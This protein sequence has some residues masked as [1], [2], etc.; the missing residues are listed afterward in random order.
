MNDSEGQPPGMPA[1]RLAGESVRLEARASGEARINQAG[2]DQHFYYGDGV[3]GA[4]RAEPGTHVQECP[5][6]GLAAFGREQARWFFGRDQLT[7]GLIARLD[8]RLRAGG[9]QVVV[10]PS[11]AGKSSLLH[12]GL[13]PKLG[14]GAL[15]GS[16]RWPTLMF[17]PTAH[18]LA[19]LATQ[20][21][22]LTNTADPASLA[23]ELATDSQRCVE[24]L[25][26]HLSNEDSEAR[27]V[28][29]V[30]QFE[31]LFTLC[32]DDQQRRACI[33]VLSQLASPRS[34]SASD[35][36]PLGLVVVGVRADFYAACA[37]DA[38]L[39]TALEDNPLVIGPMSDTELREAILYPAQDVG[40]DVEPGL[41]E[42][43]LRD[44]GDTGSATGED[45]VTSYQAGRL[46]R[47]CHRRGRGDQL[48][49]RAA[50]VAGARIAGHLAA[51]PWSHPDRGG[52]S[53]HR[54]N[55]PCRGNHSRE[56]LHQFGS[57]QSARRPDPVP[58][59]GQIGD[60]TEDTRRRMARTDLLQ[61]LDPSSALPVLDTFTQGRLLTQDQG[62]IEITHEAL[63]RAWPRLRTWIDTDR[64]GLLI[65]QRLADDAR[66]WKKDQ[67]DPASLYRGGRLA[68]V[69]VWADDHHG[70]LAPL[71]RE[72]LDA[73]V[74][75]QES[76]VL[77]QQRNTRRLR[78]LVGGLAITLVLVLLA[79]GATVFE[80]HTVSDQRR[81]AVARELAANS[82]ALATKDP[83]ASM[84]LAVEA[85]HHEST[86]ETRSALLSAQDQYF[87]GHLTGHTGPVA[88]VTFS[89]NGHILATASGDGT[90]KLWD[91]AT[92]QLIATLTGHTNIV[93][94]VAFSPDGHILATASGDKTAKLW[95]VATHQLVTTL[96][97]HTEVVEAVAFSP[98]GHTLATASDDDTAKLWDVATHQL[99][100]TLTGH[101]GAVNGVVFSPDGHTLATASVD[102]TAKLWDVATHQLIATLTGHSGDL[103]AVNFSPDG[104][105]LATASIDSSVLLWYIDDRILTPR[106]KFPI[107]EVAFSPDGHTFATAGIDKTA[108]LWDVA[109]HQLIATLTGHTGPIY[110]A[111]FSPDGHILATT[112][113]DKTAKL[114][115]VATH[116][117]IATLTGHTGSLGGVVF[118][119]DGHILATASA[120]KTVKLWDVA[121]HQLIATLTTGHTDIVEK[122]AFSPDGH[123]LA[124]TS[125]D[126][127]AKL[128]DVATHQLIA[129]LTGHTSTVEGVAFSPDGHTLATASLDGTVRT[130]DP[131]TGRV[132]DHLCHIIGIPDRAEWER[133]IPD[134]SYHPTCH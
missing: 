85:L 60:G 106:P 113:D 54:G 33:G 44:L 21:A 13:L 76:S 122:V 132:S 127:T 114:W 56:C 35:A 65:G 15:P 111:P 105:T 128:W 6:P 29:V 71:E 20:I 88:E 19:A 24:V 72:F 1:S 81:L 79:G 131:D 64:A 49:G 130:W 10:A 3:R 58:A 84:L 69:R 42:L 67:R 22:T 126:K 107:N 18:P 109:T 98:N 39:R 123:I 16:S 27:I 80:A 115:D 48:P 52:L 89:P 102:T 117:L 110:D 51:A 108:K 124:T 104:H 86:P 59:A 77:A 73:S 119:P 57:S 11:G 36:H 28:L 26:G 70:Y 134:L 96:T 103:E 62:T 30:D 55:P 78:R 14:D 9:V 23:E 38:R 46:P 8:E 2:R 41:V 129:T 101:T 31:E 66:A 4:R 93:R 121:T 118:S 68:A 90:A 95:D 116:Q 45:G 17:T 92:H 83:S 94:S 47:I 12:A 112:S 74:V 50:S 100:A 91:A 34:D 63:V 25:R 61:G 125:A 32:T 97:G 53:G 37:N 40:L 99:I 5:Y 120:D 133:L 75:A 82:S 43:L 7:A 87:A